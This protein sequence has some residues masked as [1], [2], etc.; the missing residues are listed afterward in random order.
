MVIYCT[1]KIRLQRLSELAPSFEQSYTSS[2]LVAMPRRS[3]SRSPRRRDSRE[4]DYDS[5]QNYSRSR[6]DRQQDEHPAR[7]SFLKKQS[8]KTLTIDDKKTMT[9]GNATVERS[10]TSAIAMRG[11]DIMKAALV[12]I[13]VHGL[14]ET[15]SK[16]ANADALNETDRVL[17]LLVG[18]LH[19]GSLRGLVRHRNRLRWKTR[20]NQTSSRLAC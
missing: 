19:A 18:T 1:V 10:T 14:N 9:G 3:R 4:R 16:A 17:A 7:A 5:R 6:K 12:T 13:V 8:G 11:V 2:P 20:A 15:G